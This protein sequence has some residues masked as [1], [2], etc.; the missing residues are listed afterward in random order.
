MYTALD[1]IKAGRIT[2]VE[3]VTSLSENYYPD[4]VIFSMFLVP[5]ESSN[6]ELGDVIIVE[7]MLPDTNGAYVD[8]PMVVG[9]WSPV[10][11]RA[12]KAEAIDLD[13]LDVYVAPIKEVTL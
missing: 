12:I 5:K 3:K 9:D 10:L 11:Y 13:T 6:I 1:I 8:V 2:K 4:G 7:A